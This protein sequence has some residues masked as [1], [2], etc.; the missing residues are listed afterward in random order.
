MTLP[1]VLMT[2]NPRSPDRSVAICDPSGDRANARL[3][4]GSRRAAPPSLGTSQMLLLLRG[5]HAGREQG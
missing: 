4:S 1:S 2:L 3:Y 5:V